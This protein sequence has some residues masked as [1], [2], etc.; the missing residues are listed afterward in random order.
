MGGLMVIVLFKHAPASILNVFVVI[1]V[2]VIE[3]R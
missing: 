1:V 2:V 3:W